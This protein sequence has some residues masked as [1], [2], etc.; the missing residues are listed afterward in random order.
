MIYN[1]INKMYCY[2]VWK[3]VIVIFKVIFIMRYNK[4]NIDI[5]WMM[6]LFNDISNICFVDE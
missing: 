5:F 6:V 1:L 4:K 2:I 3:F